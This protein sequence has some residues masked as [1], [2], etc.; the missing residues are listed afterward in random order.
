MTAPKKR[1][2]S[3]TRSWSNDVD[4]SGV[5]TRSHEK[6][7]QT[8]EKSSPASSVIEVSSRR[9]NSSPPRS[10]L[11]KPKPSIPSSTKACTQ[12]RTVKSKSRLTK[13][14]LLQL[15][16]AL[17]RENDNMK[18]SLEKLSEH[19]K[20]MAKRNE[21]METFHRK[22]HREQLTRIQ[23]LETD[24]WG[25]GDYQDQTCDGVLIERM[26]V[27]ASEV[28][29]FVLNTFRNHQLGKCFFMLLDQNFISQRTPGRNVSQSP[30]SDELLSAIPRFGQ[31]KDP[32]KFLVAQAVVV[33]QLMRI[34][35]DGGC[36]EL[37][38][39]SV[40]KRGYAFVE[41]LKESTSH[42]MQHS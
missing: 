19:N 7:H 8:S 42:N 23:E 41:H 25:V 31:L 18:S 16:A 34:L 14:D 20:N 12:E 22:E 21:D 29:N 39:D 13:A 37:P 27:L 15:N 2:R 3:T 17:E 5:E 33:A 9:I 24:A 10:K 36:K 40:L 26:R 6:R 32:N 1:A 28:Q 11:A 4:S 35:Q 38:F 30:V